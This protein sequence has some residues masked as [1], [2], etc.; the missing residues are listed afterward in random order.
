MTLEDDAKLGAAPQC[1]TPSTGTWWIDELGRWH[2]ADPGTAGG[3]A[4]PPLQNTAHDEAMAFRWMGMVKVRCSAHSVIVSFDVRSVQPDA[5]TSAARAVPRIA[6]G[7]A[8]H[9]RFYLCGWIH[10]IFDDPDEAVERGLALL[11]YKHIEVLPAP[12]LRSED[13][14][15]L[16]DS[17]PLLHWALTVWRNEG[18]ALG[19]K[20]RATWWRLLPYAVFVQ[21]RDQDNTLVYARIGERSALAGFVGADRKH[22]MIGRPLYG[23]DGP[24]SRCG[25]RFVAGFRRALRSGEPVLEKVRAT[26]SVQGREAEWL[27]YRRLLLPVWRPGNRYEVACVTQ[28]LRDER[29]MGNLSADRELDISFESDERLCSLAS[30]R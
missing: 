17:Q 20:H 21:E 22:T 4:V 13:A 23:E 3:H 25:E 5:V 14:E 18:V 1:F 8:V 15:G 28:M 27:S 16:D 11:N 12:L 10:E 6:K 7:R 2:D 19:A 30:R 29:P 9:L 24:M 26:F